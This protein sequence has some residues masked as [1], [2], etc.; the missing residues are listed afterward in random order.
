MRLCSTHIVLAGI[1]LAAGCA[2]VALP[3]APADAESFVAAVQAAHRAPTTATFTQ[4]ADVLAPDGTVTGTSVMDEWLS[5][6][7]HLRIDVRGDDP[8]SVL[9]HPAGRT[10]VRSDGTQVDSPRPSLAM[11]LMLDVLAEAPARWLERAR[12]AGL[13]TSIVS[14]S[15]W[16]GR[17]AFLLGAHPGQL[18]RVQLWVDAETL[19]PVRYVELSPGPDGESHVLEGRASEYRDFGGVP[20]HTR[21]LFLED[22]VPVV[23]E[24]YRDVRVDVPLEPGTFDPA[25]VARRFQGA[26]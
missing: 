1:V 21:F 20:F 6:P 13:D 2:G 12:D 25:I 4:D 15:V 24:R 3:E 8:Q 7:G 17:P 23:Q 10:L 19:L 5:I 14:S 11:L 26:G 22:G 9:Y 18:D 16:D